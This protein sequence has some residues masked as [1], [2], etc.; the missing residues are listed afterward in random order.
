MLTVKISL[1]DARQAQEVFKEM[2]LTELDSV[3]QLATDTYSVESSETEEEE[4]RDWFIET[5]EMFGF[6]ATVRQEGRIVHN[7][8][9]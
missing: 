7:S 4:I 1:I 9:Y 5:I 3:E 8:I 2:G 6:E